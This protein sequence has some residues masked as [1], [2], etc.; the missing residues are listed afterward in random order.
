[1]A[2]APK[3]ERAER[4]R[5]HYREAGL[6]RHWT[7]E[8]FYRLCFMLQCE[9][10]ELAALCCID[11]RGLW[12]YLHRDNFP[13]PASLLLDLI[14]HS[15]LSA[16]YEVK[17]ARHKTPDTPVMPIDI[18]TQRGGATVA[19]PAHNREDAGSTPAP[20]PLRSHD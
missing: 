17:D 9:P 11:L 10:E 12:Q 6:G 8:R 5:H 1:M 16:R 14:D 13:G 15:L 3:S 7:K 18:L 4:I 2:T 20:A 19:Q